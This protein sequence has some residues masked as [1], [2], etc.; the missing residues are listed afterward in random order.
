MLFLSYR[1]HVFIIYLVFAIYTIGSFAIYLERTKQG[2]I[3]NHILAG[4][5]FGTPVELE[6]R[7]IT[8]LYVGPGQTGWDGHFNI[9]YPMISSD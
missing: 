7:G 6:T 3:N 8:P 2:N 4:E 9:I 1:R 5:M